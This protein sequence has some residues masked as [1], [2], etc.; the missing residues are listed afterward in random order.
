MITI[1]S[2]EKHHPALTG[3]IT[4][5]DVKKCRHH[6]KMLV[7]DLFT[8]VKKSERTGGSPH[9]RLCLEN[10]NET[11][12]HILTYCSAY[13][14]IRSRILEEFAY[15]CMISESGVD[16]KKNPYE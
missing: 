6:I 8:Y 2:Q 5:T 9:C 10:L 14:D 7:G 13:S 1:F 12:S 3:I 15:L 11:V 16:F 4:V